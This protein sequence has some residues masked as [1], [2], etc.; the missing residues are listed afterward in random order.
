[1]S[2]VRA[3]CAALFLLTTGMLVVM[4]IETEKLPVATIGRVVVVVVVFVVDSQFP[5]L[6]ALELTG[7]STAD[8]GEE[9]QRLLPVSG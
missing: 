6:L 9:F 3:L 1:L 2:V 7:A 8:M 5:E 4:T